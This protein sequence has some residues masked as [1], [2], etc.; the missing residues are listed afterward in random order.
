MENGLNRRQ[1]EIVQMANLDKNAAMEAALVR[2]IE[3]AM[4][5]IGASTPDDNSIRRVVLAALAA[6]RMFSE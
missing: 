1:M 4:A 5:S 6:V 3:K 2:A